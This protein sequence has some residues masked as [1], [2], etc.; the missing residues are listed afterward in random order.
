MVQLTN[1]RLNLYQIFCTIDSQ[2]LYYKTFYGHDQ[3]CTIISQNV[4]HFQLLPSQS[5]KS[6]LGYD[7]RRI[8]GSTRVGSSLACYQTRE[9]STENEKKH[10]SLLQYGINYVRKELFSTDT[11]MSLSF[12][13]KFICNC[14]SCR[15]LF[16]TTKGVAFP[17]IQY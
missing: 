4:C 11:L 5:N 17:R 16:F 6:G 12:N 7:L 14:E 10:A 9:E 1:A 8:R 2:G 3:L 13:N 15:N